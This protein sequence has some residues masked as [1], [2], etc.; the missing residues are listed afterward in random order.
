VQGMFVGA[1]GPNIVYN[2]IRIYITTNTL[3]IRYSHTM[4]YP[5]SLD[6]GSSENID[7]FNV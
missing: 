5:D 1:F 4:I 2:R 6:I 7:F 3:F